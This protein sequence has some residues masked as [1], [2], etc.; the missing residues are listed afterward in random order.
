MAS[1]VDVEMK[2]L[3]QQIF[4]EL[5]PN[6]ESPIDVPLT[7]SEQPETHVEDKGDEDEEMRE[8]PARFPVIV[9]TLQ[10]I[11]GWARRRVA[12]EPEPDPLLTRLKIAE[13]ALP[14]EFAADETSEA[15]DG[16]RTSGSRSPWLLN[17][18][19]NFVYRWLLVVTVAVQYNA[20]FII[21]RAVFEELQTE[22]FA[23]WLTLDYVCDAIYIAD[24][25]FMF[26]TGYLSEG[27]PVKDLTKLRHHY[28]KSRGFALDVLSILP[29]DIFYVVTGPNAV[30]LR[31]PRLFKFHRQFTFFAKTESKT[32]KPNVLRVSRLVLY[33]ML[34]IHW[35]ACIYFAIS[36]SMGLASDHWVYPG[37]IQAND[38]SW[39]SLTRKYIYSFYWSTQILTT[40]GELPSPQED[41]QYVFVI[42]DFLIGVL[43]FATIVGNVTYTISNMNAQRN[44]FQDRMDGI[45]Q[46]MHSRSVS[47]DMED[48]VIKWFDYLWTAKYSLNEQQALDSL[49]DK[50]KADV[51]IYAHLRTLN[52]VDIFKECE[53]GL[54]V[55]LVVKL[56]HQVFSPGDYICRKG[57]VGKEMFIVQSGKLQ[58]VADDGVTELATL[59]AGCYFGEISILNLGGVGNRRTATVRALGYSHL[60][61]LAKRDLL[62]VL[63]EY[64]D[65]KQK[66][67]E[68]GRRILI[69]DGLLREGEEHVDQHVTNRKDVLSRLESVEREIAKL[70]AKLSSLQGEFNS[71]QMKVK[72]RLTSLEKK[73]ALL[74]SQ[75]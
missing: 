9:R 43:V 75:R 42:F 1:N 10:L 22:Y 57:D 11:R 64:P 13:A 58:V 26:R 14:D 31:L 37:E 47:K 72:Q 49:P 53:P 46:Y 7:H 40:I 68:Q 5:D 15:S 2:A 71:S 59:T 45:K 19:S 12:P 20:W 65:T 55:E 52:R 8:D 54:L 30:A 4:E 32:S 24:M 27:L 67:E 36:N 69:K 34:I 60:F 70:T 63:M 48:K 29:L 23:L 44:E 6:Q 38:T 18:A 66:L 61:S 74:P 33:I 51:A 25:V 16:A 3:E 62:D 73:T 56:K 41:L 35:N 28:M 39:H 21:A 50:L 17:P